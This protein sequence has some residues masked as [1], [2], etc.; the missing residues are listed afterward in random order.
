MDHRSL[1]PGTNVTELYKD[2]DY[3]YSRGGD[4]VLS[5]HSYAFNY[6]MRGSEKKM[7]EVL[8]EFLLYVKHKEDIEFVTL[9]KIFEGENK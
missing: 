8:K 9:D 1:Q 2:F 6:N 3:V 7:G 4:F 5:T